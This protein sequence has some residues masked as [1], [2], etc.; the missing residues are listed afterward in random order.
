M[1]L[2]A[3][4][5][6]N[7]VA[8]HGGVGRASRA[9]GRPKATLSRRI[10]EL[11]E[12]LGVRLVE[13]GPRALRLTEEGAALH[14]RTEGL[15]AEIA[16]AGKAI[17]G[18][19]DRPRGR[20]R[21]SAPVLISNLWL[22]RVAAGFRQACPEVRLEITAEDRRAELVEDGYDVVIRVNPPPE[23]A[24][25]GRCFVRD[26]LLVVAPPALGRAGTVPAVLMRA[27]EAPAPWRF[28][29]DGEAHAVQ[30]D[31]VLVLSTL[32]MMR[33][34]VLAGAGAAILPESLTREDIAAGRLACWGVAAG[35][36]VEIWA[37]HSA[38]RLASP[39][40][41][42]FI[43]HLASAFPDARLGEAGPG[44]AT[45]PVVHDM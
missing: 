20:L 44:L 36:E 11:E 30:P 35:A 45:A 27:E 2:L 4:A 6:F 42:A 1:D 13:R 5:D 25:V 40:V 28:T 43:R 29:A 9:S 17:G 26:R 31:P 14:A 16:E 22:G 38:R 24:L 18:G 12:S 3:L 34:A 8:T 15:L 37:L 10:M 7:L 21:V 32:P 33:Q 39:K 41:T 23:E 19:L